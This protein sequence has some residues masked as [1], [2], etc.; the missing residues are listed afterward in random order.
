MLPHISHNGA[1]SSKTVC[2]VYTCMHSLAHGSLS[3]HFS[4]LRIK[5]LHTPTDQ[6][7]SD[8]IVRCIYQMGRCLI[9]KVPYTMFDTS[10]TA[11]GQKLFLGLD[12]LEMWHHCS[13]VMSEPFS[14]I[15]LSNIDV[16]FSIF[17]GNSA[18]LGFAAPLEQL[19]DD[20]FVGS[21]LSTCLNEHIVGVEPHCC[22]L[23]W[24]WGTERFTPVYF[25]FWEHFW[26]LQKVLGFGFD[27]GNIIHVWCLLQIYFC[28][29]HCRFSACHILASFAPPAHI[30]VLFTKAN[31]DPFK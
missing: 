25:C 14:S 13:N 10:W 1:L 24:F 4:A 15:I 3:T 5:Y 29:L 11:L 6:V 28:S 26:R 12:F 20:F 19:T 22:P 31:L 7:T 30:K 17:V 8:Y 18:E 9:L 21:I 23:L 2:T 27:G 16:F